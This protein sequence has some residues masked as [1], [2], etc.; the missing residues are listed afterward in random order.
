MFSVY[1]VCMSSPN[2]CSNLEAE[3]L[4]YES[5][6]ISQCYREGGHERKNEHIIF[7]DIMQIKYF[8]SCLPCG[9]TQAL[10]YKHPLSQGEG[11]YR[12]LKVDYM[13]IPNTREASLHHA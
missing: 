6:A 5:G 12:E 9:R 10:T 7:Y 13:F 1:D 4:K 11:Q 3:M 2:D 8:V